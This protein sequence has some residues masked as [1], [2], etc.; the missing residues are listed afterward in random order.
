MNGVNL[1]HM[2]SGLPCKAVRSFPT[3]VILLFLPWFCPLIFLVPCFASL[4]GFLPVDHETI[5]QL[6]SSWASFSFVERKGIWNER[7]RKAHE[8]MS[9]GEEICSFSNFRPATL[10]V[11]NFFKQVGGWVW[12]GLMLVLFCLRGLCIS[13]RGQLQGGELKAANDWIAR[14]L[15]HGV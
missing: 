9:T 12:L 3:G 8:R 11:T 6:A 14:F 5:P 13:E 7:K 4:C 2:P 10:T 1:S 15:F